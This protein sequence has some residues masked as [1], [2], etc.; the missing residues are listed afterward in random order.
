MQRKCINKAEQLVEKKKIPNVARITHSTRIAG[1]LHK[2]ITKIAS[3]VKITDKR[4]KRKRKKKIKL[5]SLLRKECVNVYR[6]PSI[7]IMLS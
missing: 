1:S 6:S 4:K 5:L 7:L 2:C 3:I